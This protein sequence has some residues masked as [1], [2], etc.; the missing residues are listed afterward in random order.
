MVCPR[1]FEPGVF[2]DNDRSKLKGSDEEVETCVR[3]EH[4]NF[5]GS[6]LGPASSSGEARLGDLTADNVRR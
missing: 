3:T 5:V 4:S 2:R 1:I 6:R